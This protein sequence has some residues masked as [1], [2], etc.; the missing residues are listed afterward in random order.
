M[1]QLGAE[2]Y[3]PNPYSFTVLC[4]TNRCRI[5]RDKKTEMITDKEGTRKKLAV[6]YG[7]F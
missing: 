5:S 4:P 1:L 7:Q 2:V 6:R 3:L